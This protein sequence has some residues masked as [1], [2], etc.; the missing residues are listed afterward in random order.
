M[1]F[2]IVQSTNLTEQENSWVLELSDDLASFYKSKSY[3]S[4]LNELYF[5]LITVKPEFDQFFKK[6]RP[7]YSPGT[8][9]TTIDGISV[10]NTNCVE[11]DI[12]IEFSE[13][14]ALQKSK[15][16]EKVCEYIIDE[17]NCLTRLSKLK[18]FDYKSFS[19]SF[20]EYLKMKKY[21]QK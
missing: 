2:S 14:S 10:T 18:D 12:K 7:R 13:I 3:G 19:S 20:I 21:I 17:L 11:I 6:R 1:I 8:K 9:T 16:L 5:G 15:F 4:D